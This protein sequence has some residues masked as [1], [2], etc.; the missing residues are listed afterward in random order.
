MGRGSFDQANRD[1]RRITLV[2]VLRPEVFAIQVHLIAS[3]KHEA[4]QMG[5]PLDNLVQTFHHPAAE[6][7]PLVFGQDI[8]VGEVCESD[9]VSHHPH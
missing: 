4:A 8:Y 9:I 2:P 1:T 3:Q 7:F 6:A 5:P